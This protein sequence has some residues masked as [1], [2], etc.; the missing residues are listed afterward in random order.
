MTTTANDTVTSPQSPYRMELAALLDSVTDPELVGLF[1][2]AFNL[3][4]RLVRCSGRR[5]QAR[6]VPPGNCPLWVRARGTVGPGCPGWR[7][8][9]PGG[10]PRWLTG[11]AG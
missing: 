10:G 7:F 1:V 3:G 4:V 2:E 6:L 5:S 8:H 9:Q 11:E